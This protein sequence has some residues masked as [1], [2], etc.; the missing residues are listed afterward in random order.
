MPERRAV[1]QRVSCDDDAGQEPAAP[2]IL[3]PVLVTAPP[4]FSSSSEQLI[5]GKDF[6][7][8]TTLIALVKGWELL[9][10]TGGAG[11]KS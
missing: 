6:E 1:P 3:S 10:P 8:V 4:P 5:P 11:F 2:T 7:L 9:P